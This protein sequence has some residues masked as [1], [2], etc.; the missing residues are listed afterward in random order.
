MIKKS[1]VRFF[2]LWI[3]VNELLTEILYPRVNA[4]S[5]RKVREIIDKIIAY[6]KPIIC[7]T[8]F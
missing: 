5:L 1:Q 6:L 3:I 7:T 2:L 8:P 4:V